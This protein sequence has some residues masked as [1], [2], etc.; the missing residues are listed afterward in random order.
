MAL[1]PFQIHP[2]SKDSFTDINWSCIYV[3]NGCPK[4]HD[5]SIN[6]AGYPPQVANRSPW[7]LVVTYGGRRTDGRTDRKSA[8]SWLTR[9]TQPIVAHSRIFLNFCEFTY[10]QTDGWTDGWMD[11]RTDRQTDGRIDGRTDGQTDG[12]TEWQTDRWSDKTSYRVA[13]RNLKRRNI[14]SQSL[15]F[16]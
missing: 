14:A 1:L 5:C 9:P 12:P 3:L 11:K 6:K 4:N 10:R 15:L 16:C 13:L 2:N 8:H 7:L